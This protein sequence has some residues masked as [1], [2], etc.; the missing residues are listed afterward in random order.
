MALASQALEQKGTA[1]SRPVGPRC[2][3]PST[4]AR[5]RGVF[6]ASVDCV[7]AIDA[8]CRV[9]EWNPAA[10]RTFGYSRARGAGR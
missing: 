10:E 3:V 6:D 2:A 1:W 9:V 5:C 7:V 4:A 8:E